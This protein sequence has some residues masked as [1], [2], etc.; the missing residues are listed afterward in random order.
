VLI[1]E[2]KQWSVRLSGLHRDA[3]GRPFVHV[4]AGSVQ[5]ADDAALLSIA[6]QDAT[7]IAGQYRAGRRL[8]RSLAVLLGNEYSSATSEPAPIGLPPLPPS[9]PSSTEVVEA[10]PDEVEAE[11]N[12]NT[13]PTK[14]RRKR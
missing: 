13:T 3:A 5:H 7:R 4:L 8:P 2:C 10:R 1:A 14:R 6:L 9:G 11:K 12:P